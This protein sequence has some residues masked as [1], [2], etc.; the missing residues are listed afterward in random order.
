MRTILR[1][2]ALLSLALLP[3]SLSATAQ[4]S[5]PT[6]AVRFFYDPPSYEPDPAVRD[7]FT[8]PA[9]SKFDQNDKVSTDGETCFDWVLGLD[10]QDYDEAVLAKTLKLEEDETGDTATV[11]ATFS[12]FDGQPDSDREIVWSLKNVGGAWKI[13]DIWSKTNDWKVSTLECQ[14]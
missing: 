1:S 3:L 14:G 10:A 8:D 7:H 13:S 4:E 5:S 11:T 6:E 12:L 9:K 2:V